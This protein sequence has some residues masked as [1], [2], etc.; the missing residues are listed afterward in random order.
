MVFPF[1]CVALKLVSCSWAPFWGP[2]SAGVAHGSCILSA[3]LESGKK[4]QESLASLWSV[5][6]VGKVPLTLPGS[7]EFVTTY[8]L[9]ML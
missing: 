2:V 7:L 3:A 6:A 5:E 9:M 1:D 8:I 4:E